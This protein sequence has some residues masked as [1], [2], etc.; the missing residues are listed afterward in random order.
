MGVPWAGATGESVR[1]LGPW[2]G[3]CPRLVFDTEQDSDLS[4][5]QVGI[6]TL[7]TNFV[8][9]GEFP[10]LSVPQFPYL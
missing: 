8:T 5:N 1:S 6:L 3:V 7:C 10:H 2:Q 4:Q 9:L